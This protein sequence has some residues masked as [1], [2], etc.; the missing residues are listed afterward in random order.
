MQAQEIK[1]QLQAFL[2]GA[3]IIEADDAFLLD[4]RRRYR[5]RAD[6]VVQPASVENVQHVM[7]FCFEHGIAVTPQ[8]GNT[9]LC[10]AAVPDGGLL[11]SLSR[12]NRIRSISLA[13]NAITVDAGAVLQNVQQAAAEAGRLFPLSL[14]SEG[15]CQI[16]GNIAC[17]AGGLNVLRYGTMRDLV[18]GA[19]SGIAQWRVDFAFAAPC[20]KTPPAMICAICLSAAKARWASSPVRH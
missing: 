17:N 4:Q 6:W 10:G 14:A 3:E 9:G 13:D 11:L 2:S 7:R 19:G 18:L 8:G 16:G 1:R 5:G 12:L 20:I 15:S